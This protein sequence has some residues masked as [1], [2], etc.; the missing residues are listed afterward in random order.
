MDNLRIK[1]K[2]NVVFFTYNNKHIGCGFIII[3]D[4]CLYCI[5]AGHVPFSSKFD[6]LIDG[7]VISNVAGD[8]IDEFEILSDCYFA[9]KYDLAV[10]KYGVI[11]MI[12]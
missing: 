11:L 8:I 12:I 1:I 9:K 4:E 7:I 3:V 2:K 10:Y 5:T 6:S